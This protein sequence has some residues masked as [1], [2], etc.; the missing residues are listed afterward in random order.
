MLR[1]REGFD[2]TVLDRKQRI[3]DDE[4]VIDADRVAETLAK[5]A[6]TKRRVEAEKL[7]LRFF[8]NRAVIFADKLVRVLQKRFRV[9]SFW[10]RVVAVRIR[11]RELETWNY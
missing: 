7:R 4:I 10:C 8:V 11:N 2:R 6:R 3:R 9:S 1:P 5:R